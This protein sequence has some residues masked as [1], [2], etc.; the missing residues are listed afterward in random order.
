MTNEEVAHFK[1]EIM[2]HVTVVAEAAGGFLG[3]AKIS[4]EERNMIAQLENTFCNK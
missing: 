2:A 3:I 4:A 1:K